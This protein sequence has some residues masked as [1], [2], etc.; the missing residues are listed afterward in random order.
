MDHKK[1]SFEHFSKYFRV[2]NDLPENKLA[3]S[4]VIR[5][6]ENAEKINRIIWRFLESWWF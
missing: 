2:Q 3:L 4:Y 1:G 5:Q 6:N